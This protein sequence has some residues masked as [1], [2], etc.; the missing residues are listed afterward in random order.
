MRVLKSLPFT[1]AIS[2]IC[3]TVTVFCV[4]GIMMGK[5]G[6]VDRPEEKQYREMEKSYVSEIR[7]LLEEEGYENSGITM[8]WVTDETGERI[9]TVTIHHGRIDKLSKAEK[10]AL[11]EECRAIEFPDK[12]CGFCHKFLEEDL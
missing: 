9:Y 6:R 2:V 11:M 10:R 3:L 8:T 12:E 5:N 1:I 7:K 4:L